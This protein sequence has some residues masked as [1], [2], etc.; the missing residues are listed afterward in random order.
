VVRHEPEDFLVRFARHTDLEAVL[1]TAIHNAPL[2]LVWNRWRRTSA[3]S[4][5]SFHYRVLVGMRHVPLHARSVAVAQHILGTS[6]A[7]VEVA[8]PGTVPEEDDRE[9]YVAAWCSHPRAVPDKKT[10]FIPETN[11]MIPGRALYVEPGDV[12]PSS[13]PGLRY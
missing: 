6:C 12:L 10:L 1:H 9:F 11:A 7:N 4:A 2:H 5:D 13:L 8:P 3:A